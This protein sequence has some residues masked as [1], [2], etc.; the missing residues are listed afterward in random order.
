MDMSD[1]QHLPPG[2]IDSL[3]S[4]VL[5]ADQ[6]HESS[7]MAVL[8]LCSSLHRLDFGRNAGK[9]SDSMLEVLAPHW[10][11]LRSVVLRR[12]Y[13]ISSSRCFTRLPGMALQ[14]EHI[15]LD[16]CR[17]FVDAGSL[18]ACVNLQYLNV[19]G[20]AVDSPGTPYEECILPVCAHFPRL[21]H[22]DVS[23]TRASGWMDPTPSIRALARN[24]RGLQ[25]LNIAGT[26]LTGEHLSHVA[27][28]TS[29][30]SLNAS[31]LPV[32]S[33]ELDFSR[34]RNLTAL[35]LSRNP[36]LDHRSLAQLASANLPLQRLSLARTEITDDCCDALASLTSLVHLDLTSCLIQDRTVTA[37]ARALHSLR[38]LRLEYCRLSDAVFEPLASMPH[39]EHLGLRSDD[40]TSAGASA[41][42]H[43]S[44]NLKQ[45]DLGGARLTGVCVA[46]LV[47]FQ[48]QLERVYLWSTS[49]KRA[50]LQ[51]LLIAGFRENESMGTSPG[52][53]LLHRPPLARSAA[54][55]QENA[56]SSSSLIQGS[57]LHATPAY[58]LSTPPPAPRP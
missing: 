16:R 41:L 5:E 13:S 28:M 53:F 30:T 24:S 15:H 20:T 2:I 50:E 31:F 10:S 27:D 8:P 51:P 36:G 49:I 26:A 22:L 47:A 57:T 46:A 45:L 39:L 40:F 43:G 52:T 38:T 29:L 12:A 54:T 7:I 55:P 42:Q 33:F 32:R 34:L 4:L 35:D 9:V 18:R 11:S 1:L 17:H 37:I 23:Q 6:F 14:L 3:V 58:A 21:T 19:S 44:R 56:R 25:T 48:G